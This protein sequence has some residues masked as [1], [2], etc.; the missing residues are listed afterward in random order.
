MNEC[1]SL[2]FSSPISS[3]S[4]LPASL[5]RASNRLE[6]KNC[7][8]RALAFERLSVPNVIWSRP[9]PRRHKWVRGRSR[10]G[11]ESRA[12]TLTNSVSE[13]ASVNLNPLL[14]VREWQPKVWSGVG[15]PREECFGIIGRRRLEEAGRSV[16]TFQPLLTPM[17]LWQ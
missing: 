14:A 10:G 8:A 13:G 6:P 7:R 5:A 3:S 15:K 16:P 12:S 17:G 2:S 9:P 1:H 11:G 4:F